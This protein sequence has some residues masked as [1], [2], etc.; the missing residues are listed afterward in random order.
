[1]RNHLLRGAAARGALLTLALAVAGCGSKSVDDNAP[2]AYVPADTPWLFANIEPLPEATRDQF[3]RQTKA[4]WPIVIGIFD[5]AVADLD[6]TAATRSADD[7]DHDDDLDE[8]DADAA[9]DA[10]ASTAKENAA[11]AARTL[12]AVLDEIRTRDT[13]EKWEELGV[14]RDA[15]IALYGVGVL[16]VLRMELGDA[17]AFR[18]LV[19]RIERKVDSQLKVERIGDAEAWT[20]GGEH[21]RG[22]M[23]VQGNHLVLTLLPADADEALQRRV[24]GQDRPEESAAEA[25]VAFNKARGYLPYGSGWIDIRRMVALV[26]DDP[27]FAALRKAAGR[28]M[29]AIDATCREE[30]AGM[31]AKVP[32]FAFG[33]TELDTHRMTM[34]ARV[35]LA[36][37]LAQSLLA[38]KPR[39]PAGVS[40]DALVDFGIAVPVLGIRDFLVAQA[41]AVAA[42]P[43][44]CAELT[45]LNDSFAQMKA[46]ISGMVPPPAANFTGLRIA[47]TR[48][49]WPEGAAKPDFAGQL[50]V[51]S[52]SPALLAGL[53]QMAIPA[54]QQT[55]L[56]PDGVPITLPAT[57]LPADWSDVPVQVAMGDKSLALAV[58][59]DATATLPALV[60]AEPS[61][62]GVLVDATYSGRIYDAF[63]KAFDRFGALLPAEQA[64][65]M[66]AQRDLY[67]MYAQWFK[68]FDLR[69]ALAPE[70]IDFV[71]TV[72][73]TNP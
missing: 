49:A 60:K 18:A 19:A 53:A 30:V 28:D 62:E 51:A 34:H 7:A 17:E 55:V 38:I 6:R 45:G 42:A 44:R 12:R 70:G 73:L 10:A 32:M 26:P 27:G 59:N 66:K 50:L 41:D 56:K 72:E 54:L 40:K 57:I 69:V 15:H 24:L 67:A 36:P 37:A 9:T 25:L 39:T 16:P 35:D 29:P 33:Y 14:R 68:R 1:M 23:A 61:A 11:I 8:D 21:A 71:E 43:F 31:A 13:P 20:F 58:G 5:S 46:K 3:A 64:A 22:V 47:A 65:Q 52:D 4:L 48:F 2:L 63:G